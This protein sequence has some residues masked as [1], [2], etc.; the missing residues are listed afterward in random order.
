MS[1]VTN[2]SRYL[3]LLTGPWFLS[4]MLVKFPSAP[5]PG[6]WQARTLYV[7]LEKEKKIIS[8]YKYWILGYNL[9]SLWILFFNTVLECTPPRITCKEHALGCYCLIKYNPTSTLFIFYYYVKYISR[10]YT[11]YLIYRIILKK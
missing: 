3:C 5:V 7:G 4:A 8:T 1:P 10:S 9:R 11:F 6:G 2:Y